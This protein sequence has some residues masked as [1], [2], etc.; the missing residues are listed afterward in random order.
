MRNISDVADSKTGFPIAAVDKRSAKAW[1]VG[2]L[3]GPGLNRHV[4]DVDPAAHRGLPSNLVLT[5]L[6]DGMAEAGGRYAGEVA[7]GRPHEVEVSDGH[8]AAGFTDGVVAVIVIGVGDEHVPLAV[9]HVGVEVVRAGGM[10]RIVP[11][12]NPR[13]VGFVRV[14]DERNGDLRRG[15]ST[16]QRSGQRC[17]GSTSWFC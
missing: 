4:V 17:Q 8:A 7:S 6:D 5:D 12:I 10:V 3:A 11:R 2:I 15:R 1:V 14:I 16:H 9:D 13:R